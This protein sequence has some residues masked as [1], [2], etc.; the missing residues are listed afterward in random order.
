MI[1]DKLSECSSKF[2]FELQIANERSMSAGQLYTRLNSCLYEPHN[3][4]NEDLPGS[5][6]TDNSQDQ[7]NFIQVIIR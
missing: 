2:E 4:A 7:K 5:K 3:L 1:H 6:I